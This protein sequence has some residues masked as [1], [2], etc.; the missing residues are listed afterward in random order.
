MLTRQTSFSDVCGTMDALKR[1]LNQERES[2]SL[3]PA[4]TL[5]PLFSDAL[6]MLG[7]MRDR[8]ETY[9]A[10]R[11]KLRGI[12]SRL[13]RIERLDTETAE[14][15]AAILRACTESQQ[16]FADADIERMGQLA[17]EIRAV[18]NAHEHCLRQYK[19]LALETGDLFVEVKGQRPWLIAEEGKR[20]LVEDAKRA[21]Q[22][23]L[24]PEPHSSML[25]D[26]LSASR[27]HVPEG[28]APDGEPLVQFEDGGRMRMSQIRWDPEIRNFYPTEQR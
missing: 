18:A 25:L 10:F 26:W 11:E 19:D 23:W 7:R 15:A 3:E 2:V 21:Y 14:H 5:D 17:E 16:A 22:A 12:L 28:R 13:E 9:E 1:L 27:A 24:P 4:N 20:S 6:F 8:I